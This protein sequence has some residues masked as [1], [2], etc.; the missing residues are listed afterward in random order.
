MLESNDHYEMPWGKSLLL[1]HGAG[2]IINAAQW[3]F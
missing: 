3:E 2:T 1:H